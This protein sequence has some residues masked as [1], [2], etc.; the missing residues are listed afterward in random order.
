VIRAT[1][2]IA[3]KDLRQRFRDRSAII[4]GFVAPLLIATL[5]NLAFGQGEQLHFTMALV[6]EDGGEIAREL[7]T[8]VRSPQLADIVTVKDLSDAAAARRAVDTGTADAALVIPSGFSGM[9]AGDAPV[10]LEVFSSVDSKLAGEVTRSIATSFTTQL[11]SVRLSVEAGL[12]GGAPHDS[13]GR[14]VADALAAQPPEVVVERPTSDRPLKGIAYFG[15]GMAIFFV[16]FAVGFTAR[17]FFVERRQGTLD[18]IAAAPLRPVAVLAGKAVSV[19]A[20]ALASLLTM[21][22]VAGTLFKASWGSP[23]AVVALCV[24]MS[25]A[26]VALTAFVMSVSRTERQAETLASALNFAFLGA[27]PEAMRRLAALTPNGL[28]LRGFTDLA[29]G[30]PAGAALARPLVGIALFTLVVGGIAAV[31]GR[32]AVVA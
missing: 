8:T 14:L 31:T 26:V 5:M 21:S 3:A 7:V 29:T 13:V 23:V 18:R 4:V 25:A 16:L 30:A 17:G 1:L 32:R 22:L 28:A 2:T 19:F 12:A 11:T 10:S 27:A 6:D 24:A 9:V 20:Y 15:P